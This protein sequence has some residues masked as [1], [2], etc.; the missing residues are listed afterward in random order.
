MAHITQSPR[1]A[2]CRHRHRVEL[3]CWKGAHRDAVTAMVLA[4]SSVCWICRGPATTADHIQP[5][6]QGGD[7]SPENC[8]P[9]CLP[10]NSGRGTADNPFSPE[11]PTP[12]AGVPLSPRW[13]T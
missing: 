12:R 1:C 11:E 4:Q 10:C 5:R 9:A 13:R 2:K 3:P 8:R 6:S 7:D